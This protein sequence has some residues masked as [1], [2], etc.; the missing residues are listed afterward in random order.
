MNRIF[1]TFVI[2]LA[3]AIGATSLSALSACQENQEISPTASSLNFQKEMV[4]FVVRYDS[5]RPDR[6][7]Q[8][9]IGAVL[10]S[11][12]VSWRWVDDGTLRL[13]RGSYKYLEEIQ[14]VKQVRISRYP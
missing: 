7:A 4:H 11:R 10:D 8:Q 6:A 9:E 2:A 12:G 14:G 1:R 13:P 3:V 5:K